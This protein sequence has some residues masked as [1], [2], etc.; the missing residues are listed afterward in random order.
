VKFRAIQPG[1][2]GLRFQSACRRERSLVHVVYRAAMEQT[3][4]RV[5]LS[6]DRFAPSRARAFVDQVL[7]RE[8]EGIRF[9]VR[10]LVSEL[11]TNSVL[12]ARLDESDRIIVDA[13]VTPTTL[14][15]EVTNPGSGFPLP[16][17][18]GAVQLGAVS[19]RGVAIAR[20]LADRFGVS[21]DQQ[22]SV[23]AE[24]DQ[25]RVRAA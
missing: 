1:L 15:L 6:P 11:V 4:H 7:A 24:L 16:A 14:R 21:G 3:R 18:P 23:W 17:M 20:A 8:S 13:T 22:T 25:P 19:G 5:E 9:P 12:H 10:L 2:W